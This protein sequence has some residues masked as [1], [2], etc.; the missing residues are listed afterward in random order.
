LRFK[1]SVIAVVAVAS[2]PAPATAAP[3]LTIISPDKAT[4]KASAPKP[5]TLAVRNDEANDLTVKFTVLLDEGTATVK[6]QNTVVLGH[7]VKRVKLTITADQ[8]DRNTAGDLILKPADA[9]PAALPITIE[10]KKDYDWSTVLII[11]VPFAAAVALVAWAVLTTTDIKT[12]FGPANWDY[13]QS[14]ATSLTVVGA[15]LGT[16]IGAGVLPDELDLF[17]KA[18]YAGLNV[19]FGMLVLF[20]PLIYAALQNRLKDDD[21]GVAQY[22]GTLLAFIVASVATVWGVLGELGT[23]GLLFRETEKGASLATVLVWALWIVLSLLLLAAVTYA[24]R[25]MRL[26][27]SS[28]AGNRGA[29][30]DAPDSPGTWSLL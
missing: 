8:S 5:V 3:P 10:P 1:L 25:R 22:E 23:V 27:L 2:A 4:V 18:G 29:G 7:D 6:P 24:V 11:W 15:L 13:S 12:P 21:K 28:P 30:L 14:W 19:F 9:A 16:V 26:I 17:T 20:A